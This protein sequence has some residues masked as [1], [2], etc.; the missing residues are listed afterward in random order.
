[1]ISNV[2]YSAKVMLIYDSFIHI[3]LIFSYLLSKLF[4]SSSYLL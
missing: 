4:F 3:T 2:F 1:M